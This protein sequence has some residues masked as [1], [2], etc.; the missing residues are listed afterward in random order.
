L[1][2][3]LKTLRTTCNYTSLMPRTTQ[4]ATTKV[5]FPTM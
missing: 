1:V 3:Q 5:P 4:N 2:N